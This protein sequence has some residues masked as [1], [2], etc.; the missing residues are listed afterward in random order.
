MLIDSAWAVPR[1]AKHIEAANALLAYGFTAQNQC[2]FINAMGYGI[3]IDGSCV[4]DFGKKWGV[5][6]ENRGMTAAT[7]NADYYAKNIK[8]LISKFNAWI[9]S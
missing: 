5:T 2:K 8:E 7:Q 9:T 1:G 4:D 6:S 3:P